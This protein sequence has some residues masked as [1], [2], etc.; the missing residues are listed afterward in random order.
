[1]M[2]AAIRRHGLIRRLPKAILLNVAMVTLMGGLI[3]H[4]HVD[5]GDGLLFTRDLLVVVQVF[6]FL[7]A[8]GLMELPEAK[9][10][11]RSWELTLPVKG[12]FWWRSHFLSLILGGLA[13]MSVYAVIPLGMAWLSS[14]LTMLTIDIPQLMRDLWVQ[15]VLAFLIVVNLFVLR[16]PDSAQLEGSK[17]HHL[18][19]LL[20]VAIVIVLLGL[21]SWFRLTYVLIV[22]LLLLVF[23]NS[24][25]RIAE[26]LEMPEDHDSSRDNSVWASDKSL[27]KSRWYTHQAI[28]R[29]LFKWPSNWI[30]ILPFSIFFGLLLGGFNPITSD[31]DSLRF[32]NIMMSIY[33]LTSTAGYFFERLHLVDH[34]PIDR[35][36][37]LAWLVIPGTLAMGLGYGGG[38]IIVS[39]SIP[40]ESAFALI[41]TEDEYVFQVPPRCFKTSTTTEELTITAPWGETHD[42]R[43]MSWH[44]GS[45]WRFYNPYSI[46]RG[47]SQRF[48]AWQIQRIVAFVYG[49]DISADI[50]SNRYLLTDAK[51][52]VRLRKEGMNIEADFSLNNAVSSGPIFP[53]IIG[54]VVVGFLLVL[55]LNFRNLRWMVSVTRQRI[56]FWGLMVFLLF[57]HLGSTFLMTYLTE[58]WILQGYF[59]G[60]MQR[61]SQTQ[62]GAVPLV[63]GL[64]LLAVGLA[65]TLAQGQFRQ[66]EAPS[67]GCK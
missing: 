57:G 58:S 15:P 65:W 38:R 49:E 10:R 36:T 56:V 55:A 30:G 19:F 66:M 48:A 23:L 40:A 52:V 33:I 24:R 9:H 29:L 5:T 39:S 62:T 47:A 43:E 26:N 17:K 67:S 6:V 37:M 46:P 2:I 22:P 54:S 35:R 61:W 8:V 53:L 18:Q 11:C 14:G 44:E 12:N 1:M 64:T 13:M 34:L 50:I 20:Q 28:F 7:G 21:C 32:I 41:T 4:E 59:L 45:S 16:N 63:W 27:K 42:A 51:G 31:P 3:V 25:Q 60:T